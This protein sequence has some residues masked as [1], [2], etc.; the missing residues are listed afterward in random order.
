MYFS[1]KDPP[2]IAP[3]LNSFRYLLNRLFIYSKLPIIPFG[4][5][6]TQTIIM[7]LSFNPLI[8]VN[9]GMSMGSLN[10]HAQAVGGP[11]GQRGM[12]WTDRQ[13]LAWKTALIFDLIREPSLK[14]RHV[15]GCVCYDLCVCV[16]VS[17]RRDCMFDCMCVQ[18]SLWVLSTHLLVCPGPLFVSL[19]PG[20]VASLGDSMP[21]TDSR[22][23]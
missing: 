5:F 8:Y 14:Q 20:W 6:I 21:Q 7:A 1:Q 4:E 16:C 11:R 15:V 2:S 12:S 3:Y 10:T 23:V 13:R 17:W 9:P 18:V 22:R 19:S